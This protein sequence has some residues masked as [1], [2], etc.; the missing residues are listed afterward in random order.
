MCSI[1]IGRSVSR[2]SIEAVGILSVKET[3]RGIALTGPARLDLTI[4]RFGVL[5]K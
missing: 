1:L 2:Q 4:G 3:S 5:G